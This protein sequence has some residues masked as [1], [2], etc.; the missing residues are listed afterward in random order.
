[1]NFHQA[2]REPATLDQLSE[3]LADRMQEK[4]F[5]LIGEVVITD[6]LLKKQA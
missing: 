1:M 6:A 3:R 5:G 4:W 2:L